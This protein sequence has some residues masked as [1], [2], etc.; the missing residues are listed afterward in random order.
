MP[1]NAWETLVGM[2][3]GLWDII[4]YTRAH[5]VILLSR[6]YV[7]YIYHAYVRALMR[8]YACTCYIYYIIYTHVIYIYTHVRGV[9]LTGL[10]ADF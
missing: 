7:I 2:S 8:A 3:W 10:S 5:V 4:L 6:M 1:Y 9:G